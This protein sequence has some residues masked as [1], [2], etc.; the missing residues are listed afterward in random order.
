MS[1]LYSLI[2]AAILA[3]YLLTESRGIVFFSTDTKSAVPP[4]K[5]VKGSTGRRSRSFWYVGGYRGGK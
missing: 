5:A 4:G 2:G 3:G 1:K